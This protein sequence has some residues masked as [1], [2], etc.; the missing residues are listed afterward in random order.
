M[1]MENGKRLS[2][3]QFVT[4]SAGSTAAL[5]LAAC[6]GG[7]DDGGGSPRDAAQQQDQA[8]ASGPASTTYEGP[9]VALAYWNGFTGGDGPLMADL[10]KRFNSENPNIAVTMNTI[11]WADFYQRL[12]TAVASGKG[13]DVAVMHVD[14][15]ATNAARRV[16][17]PLDDLAQALELE[18]TDFGEEVWN[19][20]LYQEKRYAIPLDIHPLAAYY[21]MDVL[22]KAGIDKPPATGEELDAAMEAVKSKGGVQQPFWMPAR[23]PAHLMFQTLLWQNGGEVY[24]EDVTEA[25][26]NSPE[27]VEALQW[28]LDKQ[29]EG[30]G[31]NNVA[32]DAQYVAFKNAK[33]ATTWDGVWQ[34][35][36]LAKTKLNWDA[37]PVPQVFDEKAVWAGSHQFVIPQS[38]NADEN[39]IQAAKVFIGWMSANSLEWAKAGMVPAR[40]TAR[41]DAAFKEIEKVPALAEAIEYARFPPPVPG[42]ADVGGQSFEQA[43][44]AT[45]SGQGDPKTNLD[46]A[47]NK[48]KSLLEANAKK[49][50]A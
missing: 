35:N 24:N 40:G 34:L 33:N 31:P 6:G 49:Y 47:A 10:V 14:Q 8:A 39:K 25:A 36:D 12:P 50:Q 41:E 46:N 2:R 18:A 32:Q 17:M 15:T 9:K 28:M 27:G 5:L 4:A 11:G 20:G 48:A 26:F 22:K 1:S 23:W 13:P 45:M 7:D 29:K 37:A 3:R 21:N 16:I 42:I 38:R 30:W 44:I 19:A 43:V